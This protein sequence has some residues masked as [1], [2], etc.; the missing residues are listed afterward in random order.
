MSAFVANLFLL[1]NSTT[2]EKAKTTR[3][4]FMDWVLPSNNGRITIH[5]LTKKNGRFK[6]QFQR[7]VFFDGFSWKFGV[8]S[9]EKLVF[10]QRKTLFPLERC[11]HREKN[12]WAFSFSH[13][14]END[15]RAIR[16]LLQTILRRAFPWNQPPSQNTLPID[17]NNVRERLNLF[18]QE[19]LD[20]IK[21][22][23]YT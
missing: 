9:F 11:A 22:R 5:L 3:Y 23:G 12:S 13:W 16:R 4:M 6:S 1:L 7:S 15:C 20:L 14:V 19:I 10:L 8:S 18:E 21:K 2:P 17:M